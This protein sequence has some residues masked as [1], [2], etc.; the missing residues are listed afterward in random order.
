M[1]PYYPLSAATLD[2]IVHLQ[3]E[4][5]RRRVDE[6]HKIPFEYDDAV[7]ELIRKRCT[8]VESGG[9]MIDAILTNTVLPQ[10]SQE[11]LRRTLEGTADRAGPGRRRRDWLHLRFR[12]IG[13]RHGA[14]VDARRRP[15]PGHRSDAAHRARP[16]APRARRR[17]RLG[18]ARPGALP[19]QASLYDRRARR[20]M[21]DHRRKHQRRVRRRPGEA[22]RARQ[23]GPA[24]RWQLGAHGRLSPARSD[25]G[26]GRGIALAAPDLRPDA[27]ARSPGARPGAA[28]HDRGVFETEWRR[29]WSTDEPE[30]PAREPNAPTAKFAHQSPFEELDRRW[31]AE[32]AQREGAGPNEA[33]RPRRRPPPTRLRSIRST[34]GRKRRR[35]GRAAGPGLRVRRPLRHHRPGA[36]PSTWPATSAARP[37]AGDAAALLE[38]FLAGA[39][40]I[41]RKSRRTI[42]TP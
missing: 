4:R 8:E 25:R 22:A 2:R 33:R 36:E 26:V 7:V 24:A 29:K 5:I 38:A 42:R 9:R 10:V 12:V 3:L 27:P 40:S 37:A 17:E 1:I 14:D 18:A 32:R 28:A 13:W 21:V 41:P 23:L 31:A 16:T 15:G 11:F 20:R 6:H 39:G 35:P 34:C 30:P 19:V